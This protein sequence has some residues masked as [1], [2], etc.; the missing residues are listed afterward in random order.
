VAEVD[1]RVGAVAIFPDSGSARRRAGPLVVIACLGLCA[2]CLNYSSYQDA[3][4]V[5]RGHSQGTVAVSASAYEDDDDYVTSYWFPVEMNPRWGVANR[6]DAGLKMSVLASR[7]AEWGLVVLGVD[8]RAGIIKNYLAVTVPL[9]VAL[10]GDVFSSTNLQPGFIVTLPVMT[11]IDI[12]GSV[13]RSF[14][15][16]E[17][18]SGG[19]TWLYNAGLGIALSPSWKIRPELGWMVWENF[20]NDQVVYRQFGIGITKSE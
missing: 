11:E 12:N 15:V 20:D 9:T 16:K 8:V 10:G 7:E 4:I 1:S 6:V 3:R 18:V 2:G 19:A 13:R 17:D 14:Y 5:E